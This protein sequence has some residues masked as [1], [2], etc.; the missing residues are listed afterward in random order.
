MPVKIA[1]P[2]AVKQ[3]L[4]DLHKTQVYK[5]EETFFRHNLATLEVAL[6]TYVESWQKL[7]A[8]QAKTIEFLKSHN[9]AM[10]AQVRIFCGEPDEKESIN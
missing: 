10:N 6:T 5:K 4:N 3:T 2:D 8:E 7:V 9:E 1:L